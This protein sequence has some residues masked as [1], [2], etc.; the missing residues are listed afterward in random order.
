MTNRGPTRHRMCGLSLLVLVG[1]ALPSMGNA[2]VFNQQDNARLSDI[3]TTLQSLIQ[4]VTSSLRTL[5]PAAGVQRIQ[6]Y[7]VLEL[8]L[9]AV[10]ERA[11]AV[12]ILVAASMVMESSS[13][14]GRLLNILYGEVIPQSETYFNQKRTFILNAATAQSSD[15]VYASYS[16]TRLRRDG[17]ESLGFCGT[18]CGRRQPSPPTMKI[19]ICFL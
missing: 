12:Y 13:D 15:N 17:A 9:E 10:Q 14:Q 1:L 3:I 2:A 5:A 4:D 8:T 7:A 11:N 18:G 6:S 19:L 16:A